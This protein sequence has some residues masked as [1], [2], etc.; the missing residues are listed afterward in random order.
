[1]YHDIGYRLT[2][3]DSATTGP[4]YAWMGFGDDTYLTTKDVASYDPYMK[5]MATQR[6]LGHFTQSG[7]PKLEEASGAYRGLMFWWPEATRTQWGI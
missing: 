4:D 2:P 6:C 5:F 3:M 7:P 1:M